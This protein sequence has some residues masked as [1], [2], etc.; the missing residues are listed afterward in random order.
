VTTGQGGTSSGKGKLPAADQREIEWQLDTAPARLGDASGPVGK[1]SRQIIGSHGLRRLF[2]VRTRRR[3]FSLLPGGSDGEDR[4][5]ARAGEVSLDASEIPVDGEL[6]FLRL[7]FFSE[8]YGKPVQ[9]LVE[10]L[11]ALQ[12]DLGEHQDAVVATG[13]L[14]ELGTT[15]GGTRVPRG[16][17]FT[18]G[19]YSERCASGA[20]NLRRTVP[21]SK[22]FRALEKGKKWRKVE[23]VLEDQNRAYAPGESVR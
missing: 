17:A 4:D 13:Y 11:K 18:M 12:D 1:R 8:V 9:K 7:E 15:T 3:R 10:P 14:R 16:V 6:V 20:K 19:V 2:L 5:L 21:G 23:K 22:P